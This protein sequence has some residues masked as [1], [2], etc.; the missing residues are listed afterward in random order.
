M[1]RS[2]RLHQDRLWLLDSGNAQSSYV[3]RV[4][5]CIEPVA[6]SPSHACGLA[7]VGDYAIV[8]LSNTRENH[9][10][11]GI[12]RD[13]R[14]REKNTEARCQLIV[15]DLKLGEIVHSLRIDGVVSELYDVVALPGVRRPCALG[16][17]TDDSLGIER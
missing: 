2:P 4:R 3:D 11:T 16:F 14:L 15:F 9:A 6:L 5:G 10:F 1:P 12:A 7:F 17:K 8:G 13:D